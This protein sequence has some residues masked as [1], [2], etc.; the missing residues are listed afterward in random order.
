MIRRPPRSTRPDTLFPYTTLVR[1][2][3]RAPRA[4]PDRAAADREARRRSLRRPQAPAAD[5]ARRVPRARAA[6]FL[7]D[8][9]GFH[10]G[11][12]RARL[13]DR[14]KPQ[15]DR[16]GIWR[17]SKNTQ[18]LPPPAGLRQGRKRVVEGKNV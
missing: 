16:K 2:A 7:R 11:L 8:E 10:G 6:R 1:S 18:K 3:A 12:W 14:A 5:D 17:A 4:Q 13:P 15:T 9:P